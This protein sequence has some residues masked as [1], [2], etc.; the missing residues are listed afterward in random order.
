[1]RVFLTGA[2]GY[3]GRL[4]TEHLTRMPEVEGITGISRTA[5]AGPVPGKL[6]FVPMDICSPDLKDAMAGHDVVIHTAG[7]V[8]WLANMPATR[9]DEINLGGTLN[10]AHAALDC[11]VRRFI[12][13]SSMAA[14]DPR[15]A[16]GKSGID[17]KFPLGQGDSPFYYWNS[18]AAAE[19]IVSKVLGTKTLLT[20]FRPIHIIGPRNRPT[21]CRYRENAVNLRGYNCRRQFIHEDDVAAAFLQAVRTEMPGPF[22]IVPDDCIRL[23]EVWTVIGTQRVVTVPLW[24]ARLVTWLRWRWFGSPIH[25]SWVR[26]SLVDFTGANQRLK[27]AGWKPNYC[28]EDA[29]RSAL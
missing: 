18:K 14:Y 23:N 4:L 17:E 28:S 25:P 26:D 24:T 10:V 22:N 9:R 3:L 11:G 19:N 15:L 8:L 2:S 16:K 12:H 6:R 29:L 27:A 7:V 13:A 1:M 5:P 20:L 21:L